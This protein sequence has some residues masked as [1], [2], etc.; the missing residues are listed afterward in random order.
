MTGSHG[1]SSGGRSGQI[2]LTPLWEKDKFAKA[3]GKARPGIVTTGLVSDPSLVNAKIGRENGAVASSSSQALGILY[4]SAGF[5]YSLQQITDPV[6]RLDNVPSEVTVKYWADAQGK[7]FLY[8]QGGS[9]GEAPHY[10]PSTARRIWINGRT[11]IDLDQKRLRVAMMLM[12]A[13]QEKIQTVGRALPDHLLQNGF[14]NLTLDEG[15][16]NVLAYF[17]RIMTLGELAPVQ[18][19]LF[20]AVRYSS[21]P[22]LKVWLADI[23]MACAGKSALDG[24]TR[25]SAINWQNE[26]TR[27]YLT[28][29]FKL[30]NSAQVDCMS[31]FLRMCQAPPAEKYLPFEPFDINQYGGYGWKFYAGAY[32]QA[33]VRN[34]GLAKLQNAILA[35]MAPIQIL[36]M[37]GLD[38]RL[39]L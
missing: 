12:Q 33:R 2:E 16:D 19:L 25:S 14:G 13:A 32:D 10:L 18:V 37:L 3:K 5:D 38:E 17:G 34:R 22:N 15:S 7:F 39:P 31:A 6:F 1:S 23:Y 20:D 9:D 27:A 11:F 36:K 28:E 26:E 8:F 30:T 29:A 24:S 35:H 21:N 4:G